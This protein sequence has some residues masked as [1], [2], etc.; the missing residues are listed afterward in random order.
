VER[1]TVLPE[2]LGGDR[3]TMHLAAFLLPHSHFKLTYF[4]KNILLFYFRRVNSIFNSF[5]GLVLR[6]TAFG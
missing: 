2:R 4:V 1:L 3:C 5:L 6:K